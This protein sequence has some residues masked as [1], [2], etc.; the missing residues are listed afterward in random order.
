MAC[1]N[2]KKNA[3]SVVKQLKNIVKGKKPNGEPKTPCQTKRE[4]EQDW[5]NTSEEGKKLKAFSKP[6]INETMILIFF[7]WIP[8][9][10]GYISIVKFIIG[11]F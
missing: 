10:I 8:L 7:A 5:L 1:K 3:K 4:N 6:N 11:L 9:L 2:C